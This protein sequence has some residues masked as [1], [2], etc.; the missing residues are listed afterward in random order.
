VE[1][2]AQLRI[3]VL[4]TINDRDRD[5]IDLFMSFLVENAVEVAAVIEWIDSG[6]KSLSLRDWLR[7]HGWSMIEWLEG[8]ISRR[9]LRRRWAS[10]HACQRSDAKP[11]VAAKLSGCKRM[12]LAPT[13]SAIN[14]VRNLELDVILDT[15]NIGT[16][17]GL[18]GIARAGVLS[19]SIGG[20][21]Q[22]GER[23]QVVTC[24][25]F[26]EV[27]RNDAYTQV[28]LR[29]QTA[30][31]TLLLREATY[32]TYPYSW[33]ENRRR[34]RWRSLL[35]MIDAMQ[36]LSHKSPMCRLGAADGLFL[37]AK[38]AVGEPRVLE[39]LIAL[40]KTAYRVATK[41]LGQWFFREQWCLLLAR[42]SLTDVKLAEMRMMRPPADRFWADP[43]LIE[44]N[45]QTWLFFEELK[46]NEHIGR[47]SCARLEDDFSGIRELSTI[48][49]PKHHLSYP[50]VFS[51]LHT[52][53]MIPECHEAGRIELWRC[54][55]FPMNWE[56]HRTIFSGV[57]A[58]DTSVV[59][60]DG[61]WWLFT[62]ID[63]SRLKLFDTE[64]Y[65]YYADDPIDGEWWPHRRNPVV[66][67]AR[68]ARM[69]GAFIAS[70]EGRLYRCAQIGG[71]RYGE[72][73]LF[74]EILTLTPDAFDERVIEVVDPRWRRDAIGI[75]HCH[76]LSA[77]TV[78]DVNIRT[79]RFLT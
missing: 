4:V 61:R 35:L 76:H 41:L 32:P 70:E 52:L 1:V 11:T 45:N 62:N 12:A 64:L 8:A 22:G 40:A 5:L 14:L 37:L 68:K 15:R 24:Q 7:V 74:C 36:D 2:S 60:H 69:A 31:E 63:R 71:Q 57:E 19:L 51:H 49:A 50:F 10:L 17:H 20:F 53:Y 72:G 48:L 26:H 33:S 58:V 66:V 38:E 47:I 55:Q 65:I 16:D 6:A 18:R 30:K 59:H 3:G 77:A 39:G 28:R 9:A 29:W 79:P 21:D 78:F 56:L 27:Y 67:D 46:Y 13:A 23:H 54:V 25:G 73:L 75:H 43:F 42:G 34:L 44:Y